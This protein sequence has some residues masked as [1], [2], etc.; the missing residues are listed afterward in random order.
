MITLF[1]SQVV[2]RTILQLFF[3]CLLHG[4]HNPVL[5]DIPE[6]HCPDNSSNATNSAYRGNLQELTSW[7]IKNASSSKFFEDSSG[8][9]PN[10]VYGQ[11]MC[12]NYVPNSTCRSCIVKGSEDILELCP[13]KMEAVVWEDSCQLRISDQ[14]FF[15]R[16]FEIYKHQ[17]NPKNISDP[18]KFG[19]V[20]DETLSFLA[21]KAVLES[22]GTYYATKEKEFELGTNQTLYA[23][24]Q[25]TQ[26]LTADDCRKC[27]QEA[28]RHVKDCCYF[29]LGARVLSPSCYLRYELYDFYGTNEPVKK[30]AGKKWL[31][32]VLTISLLCLAAISLCSWIFFIVIKRKKDLAD[33]QDQPLVTGD[34]AHGILPLRY[35]PG[36]TLTEIQDHPYFDMR[37]ILAATDNFSDTLKLGQ[38]GFGPVYK[39]ILWDGREVAVKRL[40]SWSEKGSEEFRNEVLLIMKLQHKNL[41]RL[42]GFCAEREEKLLVYEYMPNR[43]LDVFLFDAQRRIELSW[44]RRLNIIIGVARGLLYLHEDSRQRIIYRDLKA[45][46][47]LLDCDMNPKISDFGLARIFAGTENEANTATLVGTY[48]YMAP[49]YAMEGLYSI[50]SDVYSFGVLLLEII[51]GE[52]NAGFWQS[53]RASSLLAYA[54]QLWNEGRAMELMDPLLHNECCPEEFMKCVHVGLLCVQEDAFDRPTMSAVNVMLKMDAVI[55][56]QPFK[57]AFSVSGFTHWSNGGVEDS[58]CSVNRLTVST[59]APR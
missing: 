23:L 43:S 6:K 5:A 36:N 37:C 13:N 42:L 50:K 51:T 48:G 16:L 27:L 21:R 49:E 22:P 3:H 53:R 31:I 24:V 57:P 41:V 20:V 52:R 8:N 34:S 15:G 12:L 32:K 18:G 45:S 17:F 40:E 46:N 33:K 58:D 59:V 56:H 55:L 39:G 7:M 29:S 44:S 1:R 4:F 10:K 26:N 47:V 25:C 19:S 2:S 11:Y 38:G 54:W 30:S 35:I 9:S 28:T 14:K